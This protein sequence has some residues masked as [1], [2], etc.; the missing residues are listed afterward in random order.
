MKWSTDKKILKNDVEY[1]T[2]LDYNEDGEDSWFLYDIFTYFKEDKKNG[3]F[4]EGFYWC[5]INEYDEQTWRYVAT[6]PNMWCVIEPPTK[7]N[8]K[9]EI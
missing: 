3:I 8:N 5:D 6:Q 9:E 4:S 2:C 1:L 7:E